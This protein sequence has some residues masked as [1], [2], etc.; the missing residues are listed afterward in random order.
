LKSAGA[1]RLPPLTIDLTPKAVRV[2][3]LRV[4]FLTPTELKS[5]GAVLREPR[6]D[7]L[8]ARARDRVSSLSMLYQG[9]AP[10]TD[11]LAMGERSRSV[12]TTDAH[13]TQ[14]EFERRSGRTGQR[15]GLGGFTGQAEY[16]GDLT[17]LCH[18]WRRPDGRVSV[19]KPFG[20]MA[21]LPS[22]LQDEY[23]GAAAIS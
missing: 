15:H 8:L 17:S 18:G 4:T 9:G 5:G 2:D 3:R 1:H 20:D 13:I 7:A 21:R 14:V 10:E 11:Y 22:K 16:A 19:G 23:S 12:I 6:F